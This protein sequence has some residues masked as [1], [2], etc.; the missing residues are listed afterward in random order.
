MSENVPAKNDPVEIPNAR[1]QGELSGVRATA[2]SFSGPIPPP[3]LLGNYERIC[4]GSADRI[5][6]MAERE[7]EHRRSLE[8]AIVNAEIEEGVR[9]SNEARRG[10]VCALFIT[11]TAIVL[12]AYVALQGREIAGSV[13][14]AGGIGGVVTTFIIGRAQNKPQASP[15]PPKPKTGRRKRDGN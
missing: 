7:G 2:A 8:Q 14:G 10:Q 12:G 11:M 1:R 3:D 6:K 4:P 5:I 13:I 9:D 15:E